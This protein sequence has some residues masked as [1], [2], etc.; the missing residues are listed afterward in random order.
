MA[1]NKV[2]F[3]IEKLYYS[4]ITEE[5]GGVI[6]YGDPVHLPGAVSMELS[7]KGETND[8]YADNIAYYTTVSNQGYEGTITVA[9][10]TEAFK[11]NVLGETLDTTDKV[12]TETSSANPKKLAIMVE[13]DGDQKATRHCLYYCTLTRPGLSATTK[14]ET[15]E[16]GTSE[17]TFVAGPRPGDNVVK[18]STTTETTSTVYDGWFT[19]VYEPTA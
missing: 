16:P 1:E 3:G 7:I 14:T 15:A 6:T 2:N 18:R 8:F 17:L 11:T 9:N 13:F 10:I 12:L 5:T 4:V 19:K